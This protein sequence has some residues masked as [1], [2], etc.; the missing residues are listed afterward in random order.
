MQPI[1]YK[2]SDVLTNPEKF[3]NVEYIFSTWGMP[4][5]TKEEVNA[6][7]PALKCIFYAAGTVR[8]FAKGFLEAGVKVFSSWAANAIPV[9]EY[10]T[11]QIVLA[12]KGF[13]ATSRIYK[14]G[15]YSRARALYETYLGNYNIN[16]GIIG[17]GM[18]GKKV[19]A[20]LKSH[21]VNVLVFDPFLPDEKAQELGVKKC[22]LEELFEKC[23]VLS[24]HL[25]DNEQTRGML[26]GKLF[27]SMQKNA[28]FINTGRGAQVK[29][30]E[31]ISVL[32][33][34]PDLTALLDVTHPEPIPIG[35]ELYA[36]ENCI[37]T[38]HIAGSNGNELER[39]S[40]FIVEEFER[41]EKGENCLYEVTLEMMK[42]MA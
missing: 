2:K 16:V 42:T 41:F 11:A 25:A 8:F 38:P 3:K 33:D 32:K 26:T 15:D 4:A 31:L 17:A 12:S 27:E 18:I 30:S 1:V 6:Y 35:S 19:I 14:Q 36:L 24:N 7:L 5:F 21:Q 37:F 29:E 9:A 23:Y 10:A 20:L 22:S 40:A 13:F 39:M 28:T 34:R